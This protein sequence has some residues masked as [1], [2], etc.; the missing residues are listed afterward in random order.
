LGE[1]PSNYGFK[2]DLVKSYALL[3]LLYELDGGGHVRRDVEDVLP[4]IA[5]K[6][7]PGQIDEAKIFAKKWKDSHPPLSF[8]PDKL[9]Y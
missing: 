3:S 4:D 7:S 8:Y 2:L 5:K 1:D 9:G 6:M